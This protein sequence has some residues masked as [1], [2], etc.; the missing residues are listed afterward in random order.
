MG[1]LTISHPQLLEISR[2]REFFK[3]ADT[4]VEQCDLRNLL[5][6]DTSMEIA[7]RHLK[8]SFDNKPPTST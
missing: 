3:M 1:H 5:V 4:L 8:G 2:W 6:G 7:M